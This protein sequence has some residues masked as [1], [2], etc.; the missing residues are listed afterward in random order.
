MMRDAFTEIVD[1]AGLF[2]PATCS[3]ADAVRL[4]DVYRRSS[5]RWMLGRFVVAAMRLEELSEALRAGS[6]PL[7]AGDPW[8]LAVVMGAVVPTELDRIAAFHDAWGD[9]G[10]IADTIE[11]RVNAVGQ[12]LEL[13]QQIPGSFRRFFEVPTGKDAAAIVR[14]IGS[15]G[16]FAKIRTGGTSAD[17]FPTA[18]DLAT[19][20]MA[21]VKY[22]VPFKA[23]AGLHHPFHGNYP[24][25]YA[26]DAQRQPM[27]GFVNLLVATAEALRGGSPEIVAT[28]LQSERGAF[29]R[30]V[31]TLAWDEDPYSMAELVE[32]H[33]RFF[34]G[35][36]SCSF[37]EPYDELDLDRAA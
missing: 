4:Y 31:D 22:R 6:V 35:F 9:V 7:E 37:R 26:P 23:T 3:M 28:I 34:L 36:G 15:I 20:I 17:L 14:S 27:Y 18:K 16:A 12:V 32:A 30:G 11:Y 33:A 5:D 29:T 21:A 2:P 19:F 1:Y 25:T 24:I 13:D 10:V 8:R